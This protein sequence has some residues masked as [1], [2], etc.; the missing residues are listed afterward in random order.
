MIEFADVPRMHKS[1]RIDCGPRLLL[2]FVIP[3]KN[4]S[5]PH[6]NFPISLGVRIVDGYLHPMQHHTRL[7]QRLVSCEGFH[8]LR[9][10]QSVWAGHLA[11]AE[12]VLQIDV[13]VEK[14][15]AG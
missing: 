14:V 13:E 12:D 6:A 4:I 15:F 5:P 10:A 9:V 8:G 1:F 3:H 7:F 2:V 11:H